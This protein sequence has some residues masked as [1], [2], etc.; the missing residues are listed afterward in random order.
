MHA[1]SPRRDAL[2]L[3]RVVLRGA[4][5]ARPDPLR[6]RLR[7]ERTLAATDWTPAGLPPGALLFVRRLRVHGPGFDVPGRASAGGRDPFAD[8]RVFAERVA[9]TLR[10]QG[11]AARRP[12]SD[13]AAADAEAVWFE[14][15]DELAACLVR[16]W[17]RGR[18]AQRW[19]WRSVLGG[20]GI[21][22]WLRRELL[23]R[24]ERLAP[25]LHRLAAA[26]SAVAWLSRM[27]EADARAGLT[28]LVRAYALPHLRVDGSDAMQPAGPGSSDADRDPVSG[29][30]TSAST[31][32]LARRRLQRIV[33]ELRAVAW[34]PAQ[35]RLLACG[36]A[37]LRAPTEARTRRFAEDLDAWRPA[38]DADDMDT[39]AGVAPAAED[40][41][42][43]DARPD[44]IDALP[45]MSS[46]VRTQVGGRLRRA[47]IANQ[48]PGPVPTKLRDALGETAEVPP[49]NTTHADIDERS[50]ASGD[51]D[52]RPAA[53]PCAT[54]SMPDGDPVP[55]ALEALAPATVATPVIAQPRDVEPA[56]PDAM[57]VVRAR[58]IVTA[59]GGLFYLLNAALT[60][61]LYGDFTAPRAQG[62]SLSPW[63]LLAWLG[64]HWFG[65]AFRRDP[66]WR[67]LA[68]LAG[69]A[70]KRAPSWRVDPP[71]QW[72]PEDDWLHPW[73]PMATLEHG[74]DRCARRLQLRHP[75]GFAVFDVPRDTRLRPSAQAR[76]L[77]LSREAVMRA[78]LRPSPSMSSPALP[79]DPGLRWLHR[80][81]E[82]MAARLMRALGTA[83]PCEAVALLCR[84]AAEVR[85]DASRVEI[86]L[87][88]AH[89]PLPVRIA[90]LDRDPGWIPAAGRDVRFHFS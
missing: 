59:H 41:P 19:W 78:R 87:S 20:D 54:S 67:L 43:E 16:D 74:V 3:D 48:S 8:D 53:S 66:L 18:I 62:L 50:R 11:R 73:A 30:S 24:G 47:R 58:T 63:D 23:A 60:L 88:L 4:E 71:S 35:A 89:L 13:D 1:G 34:R 36:L 46:R 45:R 28:S 79:V 64:Q 81:A 6:A 32:R 76:A 42:M 2:R 22:T 44:R 26:S 40:P 21:D 84:H 5:D 56:A 14:D 27:D 83:S 70:P 51:V 55:P 61:G 82:Y 52:A 12:W 57:P 49:L 37:L 86:A 85:C 65:R 69:R 9:E 77:C 80:F 29:R 31:P 25:T 10:A 38:T 72:A 17:L 7:L 33:P 68:D 39:R 90:G 15:E 75:A